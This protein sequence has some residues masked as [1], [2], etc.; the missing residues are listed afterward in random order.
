MVQN[1]AIET[2]KL[3]KDYPGV[4]AVSDIDLRIP[5]G[6]VHGFLGPNGAGKSTTLRMVCGLL[7]PTS[8]QVR[9]MGLD[10]HVE[11]TPGQVGWLPEVPPLYP[12]MAVT[13]FLSFAGKLQGISRTALAPALDRVIEQTGLAHVRQRL[14]G[15]LSK[16]YRQ[17]VGIAQ[18]L[19]HDPAVVVLDEP[20]AGLDPQSVVEIRSLVRALKGDKT[21]VF[22]SHILHEVEAVCDTISIIDQGVL[23]V[24]GTLAEVKA[25]FRGGE[26]YL[27]ELGRAPSEEEFAGL[28][29]LPYVASMTLEGRQLRVHPKGSDDVRGLLVRALVGQNLDVLAL[30]R[31]GADLED[32]FL[33]LTHRGDA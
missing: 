11:G 16:G 12:E 29:G 21:V 32:V 30:S 2:E 27:L 7:R 17:R 25:S 19:I 15:N 5:T 22:S 24:S 8:G 28:R 31:Q 13:E 10:P 18:A 26:S 3:R 14:I 20:T 4:T 33:R 23:R 6:V 1:W 9:L